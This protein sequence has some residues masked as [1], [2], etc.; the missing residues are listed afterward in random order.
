MFH[1]KESHKY[2]QNYC[3]FILNLMNSNENKSNEYSLGPTVQH[4]MLNII[5]KKFELLSSLD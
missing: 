4:E 3:G 1:V 2:Y 5:T